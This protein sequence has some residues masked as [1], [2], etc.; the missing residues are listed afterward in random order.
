MSS[1]E[2]SRPD[3]LSTRVVRDVETLKAL[4]DPLRLAILGILMDGAHTAP[5]VRTVKELAAELDEPTTKLYRHIKQLEARGLIEVAETRVVSGIVEH[6][7]RAG[8]Q[9]IYMHPDM[10]GPDDVGLDDAATALAAAMD[11]YRNEFVAAVRTGRAWFDDQPPEESFRKVVAMVNSVSV[12]P[13]EAAGFR[14][15]LAALVDDIAASRHDPDGVPIRVLA[16]FYSP[17]EKPASG[18]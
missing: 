12:S 4:S 16:A 17:S 10:F 13:A 7:Y 18:E 8:Q 15:R 9:T 1:P 6:R 11:D 14:D 5:K 2:P 3:P